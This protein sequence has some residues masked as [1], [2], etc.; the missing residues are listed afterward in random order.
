MPEAG[1]PERYADA[2]DYIPYVTALS[3]L[4]RGQPACCGEIYSTHPCVQAMLPEG[5]EKY[6]FY[7][8]FHIVS[9]P[10]SDTQIIIEP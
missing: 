10:L 4:C 9:L 7:C 3:I 2:I 1:I 6:L 8:L 5:M